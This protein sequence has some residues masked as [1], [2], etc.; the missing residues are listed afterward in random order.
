MIEISNNNCHTVPN[1]NDCKIEWK[2]KLLFYHNA[3][4]NLPE[5]FLFHNN[6]IVVP[7]NWFTSNSKSMNT[8]TV[9]KYFNFK[10]TTPKKTTA[11]SLHGN[12]N[13]NQSIKYINNA[14]SLTLIRDS[15]ESHQYYKNVDEYFQSLTTL[16]KGIESSDIDSLVYRVT[17]KLLD[18]L[19]HDKP[20]LS[21]TLDSSLKKRKS[22]MSDSDSNTSID[23]DRKTKSLKLTSKELANNQ[24]LDKFKNLSE[25]DKNL[26]SFDFILEN[27]KEP[28]Y[29]D[30]SQPVPFMH[31]DMKLFQYQR[32][33]LEKMMK[34][35]RGE[36]G[37][38]KGGI[39]CE[40]MGTGKTIICISLILSTLGSHSV[41]DKSWK[42]KYL[43]PKKPTAEQASRALVQVPDIEMEDIQLPKVSTLVKMSS[44]LI[45]KIGV[46]YKTLGL[47]RDVE[48]AIDDVPNL[49]GS[50]YKSTAGSRSI[51]ILKRKLICCPTTLIIVPKSIFN[52]WKYELLYHQKIRFLSVD[53]TDSLN[54][55]PL[56]R[57]IIKYDVLLV[58]QHRISVDRKL[59]VQ[60]GFV[61]V[62]DKVTDIHPL[63]Q[64]HFRRI[65][66]DEGHV[67][68]N[69][70]NL[71]QYCHMISGESKFICS[72]TP[73]GGSTL[74]FSELTNVKSLVKFLEISP[75]NDPKHWNSQISRPIKDFKRSGVDKLLE[76]FSNY[77]IRTPMS[78]ILNEV[79]LV[80]PNISVVQL[81]L[82]E[83]QIL[84]YNV[85][86]ALVQ[87]NLL[88]SQY[89]GV[90]SLF[91]SQNH[92]HVMDAFRN[93]KQACFYYEDAPESLRIDCREAIINSLLKPDSVVPVHDKLSLLKI[94]RFLELVSEK[95]LIKMELHRK[96]T[97]IQHKLKQ[98]FD[99]YDLNKDQQLTP[100]EFQSILTYLNIVDANH[101]ITSP[102]ISFLEFQNLIQSNQSY[103]DIIYNFNIEPPTIQDVNNISIDTNTNNNNNNNVN[104]TT[105]TK[106][107]PKS[108]PKK[109]KQ[110]N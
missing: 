34:L 86:I 5:S 32:N 22:S 81:N 109:T 31:R 88:T 82:H 104:T 8:S 70:T 52:Q 76:V 63:L 28:L 38:I 13:G 60:D 55:F 83:D 20:R 53:G 26:F 43:K 78:R 11:T 72:G 93:L 69:T 73:L 100:E 92:K 33:S 25:Q 27:I 9:K 37:S 39:L 3:L 61:E 98:I 23:S 35:E 67:V 19:Q 41:P 102:T 106:K 47:N 56:A 48:N 42:L 6:S 95:L 96:E 68:G 17:Q 84:T 103:K 2:D 105:T 89:E 66:V 79:E 87:T 94:Y 108:S 16:I 107:S 7:T 58:P 80:P 59:K 18:K 85:I 44:K 90:D 14:T 71:T 74:L 15:I 101:N 21:T 10:T 4:M 97:Q 57:K 110:K 29:V 49:V 12:S 75:Y 40:P 24:M 99:R 1:D 51:S 36:F 46:P 62:G 64:I 91:S 65:I 45:K 77:G 50:I 30:N 54:G